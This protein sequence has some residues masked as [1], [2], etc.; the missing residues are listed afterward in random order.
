MYAKESS[1]AFLLSNDARSLN[2]LRQISDERMISTDGNRCYLKKLTVKPFISVF[3]WF[4]IEYEVKTRKFRENLESFSIELFRRALEYFSQRFE[5]D[6]ALKII[7]CFRQLYQYALSH[8]LLAVIRAYEMMA[9][10]SVS[11]PPTD[12]RDDFMMRL[13]NT[14]DCISDYFPEADFF[15][16]FYSFICHCRLI[17]LVLGGT[18][19]DMIN[20]SQFDDGQSTMAQSFAATSLEDNHFCV[21]CIR[22]EESKACE[23]DLEP[24][25]KR[26]RPSDDL[27]DCSIIPTAAVCKVGTPLVLVSTSI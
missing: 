19:L 12:S 27:R 11:G 25:H 23:D 9:N 18:I 17:G 13:D 20:Y 7:L 2:L 4:V 16:G 8:P 1:A 14:T 15:R 6:D 21:K 5:L 10:I 22:I 3:P 24:R 26:I